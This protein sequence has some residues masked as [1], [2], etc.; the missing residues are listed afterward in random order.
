MD[1]LPLNP[2][3]YQINTRVLMRAMST[4]LGRQAGFDD[5]PDEA[6]AALRALGFDWLWFLGVWQTGAAGRAIS[7]ETASWQPGFRQ[8]LPDLSPEDVCGSPFAVAGYGAEAAFGGNPALARLRARANQ[9]GLRLMLDFVPNHMAP[10]H[11]WASLR[12]SLFVR[13]TEADLSAQ[14]QNWLRLEHGIVAHGRDPYFP[15]WPDTIQLDYANPETQTAMAEMLLSVASQCDGVRCDMAMLLLPDV[16]ERTWAVQLDGRRVPPFW[17]DAIAAARMLH[18]GVCF[19][20][21]VYW[22]LEHR[23]IGEGFDV[24]YDKALYDGLR[25]GDAGRVRD[26]LS[27]EPGRQAH[28]ARFLENHDE[29]RAAATF[30]WPQ[31]RAAALLALAAPGLRFLHQG[32]LEGLRTH[33]PI[34]LDRGPDEPVDEAVLG[35]YR[36]LL[37]VLAEPALRSGRYEALA[38]VAAWDGNSSHERFVAALWHD[39]SGPRYLVAANYGPDRGQCRLPMLLG[40]GTIALSD[41]LGPERYERDGAEIMTAGLY[42]DLPGWGCNLF[43]IG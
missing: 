29:P 19:M 6:L 43:A 7:R 38:P 39:G 32:Q 13:G 17:P 9:A 36:A 24:A 26:G 11:P 8:A 15:G 18:P 10:D 34:H 37:P 33:I 12:P 16:F 28:L 1:A 30:A 2:L 35:F 14:P 27:A 25:D 4:V 40:E 42:L 3:L 41:R 5:V 23:L 21:E 31:H 20:A 22:G